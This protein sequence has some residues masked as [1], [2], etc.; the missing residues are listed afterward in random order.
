[1]QVV[2]QKRLSLAINRD[3]RK[4][5]N[6][7]S[8]CCAVLSY[9]WLFET[10]RTAAHRMPLSMG[11]FQ[12]RMLEW[13]AVSY[14]WGS[15]QPRDRT[16]VSWV[17]SIVKQILY[18]CAAWETHLPSLERC[19]FIIKS[20]GHLM[21]F[22]VPLLVTQYVSCYSFLSFLFFPEIIISY[23]GSANYL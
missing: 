19:L 10:P 22:F 13:I 20:E 6:I 8:A 2:S 14:S 18:H 5:K 4:S 11:C 16:H 23:V 21:F 3:L 9:F 12:A 17:F 1:M 7:H 15:S